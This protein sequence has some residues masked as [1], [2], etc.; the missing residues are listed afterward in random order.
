M[1]PQADE[2]MV[3]PRLSRRAYGRGHGYTL[4]GAKVPGVT[5]ILS[6]A[7]PMQ[8][9]QWASNI[10]ANYAVEHWDELAG[11][12]LTARLD[13]IRYAHRDTLSE[14]A[15]RGT[16]IHGYG[17]AIVTGEAVEIPDEYRGPAQAYARFLDEWE[18]EPVAI[19]TPLA[20][21]TASYAGT[22]DLWARVG[23]RDNATA[24]IDLKTG[25]NVY[26]SAV[27]QLAAYRF[28]DL[29]QPDGPDSEEDLPEVDLVYVAHLLPDTVRMLPVHATRAEHRAFLYVAQTY[30]WLQA[31][32]FKGDQ[33]LIGD[34][35]VALGRVAS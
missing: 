10:A 25:K 1:T 18:I 13:R 14:A 29:W 15:L 5:T 23:A 35:E 30:D 3:V 33:P 2:S 32:G 19:E 22:A 34:A 24:L 9:K 11:E 28:A 7:L 26:E 16:R 12:T 17:E 6:G 8:L 20:S 31:H 4:D 21:T 27:L